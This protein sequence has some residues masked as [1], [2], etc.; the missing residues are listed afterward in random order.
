MLDYPGSVA[1]VRTSII[2]AESDFR[3]ITVGPE[4]SIEVEASGTLEADINADLRAGLT[5]S[6]VQVSVPPAAG[7][8]GTLSINV[9]QPRRSSSKYFT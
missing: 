6:T 7:T 8:N 4:F 2:V 1:V 5:I 9:D 3:I